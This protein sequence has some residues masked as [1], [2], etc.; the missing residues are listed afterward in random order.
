MDVAALGMIG[1]IIV[2]LVAWL[3][4]RNVE[5]L[6]SELSTAADRFRHDL[7]RDLIAQ[8]FRFPKEAE[9]AAEVLATSL[10]YLQAVRN[11]SGLYRTTGREVADVELRW[12]SLLPQEERYR[13]AVAKATVHLPDEV[14]VVLQDLLKARV[15]IY[16]NQW[17]WAVAMVHR[18]EAEFAPER[19]EKAFGASSEE[20]LKTIEKRLLET[21]KPLVRLERT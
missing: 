3:N 8:F 10:D 18:D 6:K 2:A 20:K 1:S 19:F 13:A 7:V 9:V 12:R 5:H 4:S 16:V 11:A 15:E 17:G 14:Q 21:L